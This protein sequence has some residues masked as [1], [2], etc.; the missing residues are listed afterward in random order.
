M[1]GVPS[2]LL[3]FIAAI[4]ATALAIFSESNS[5]RFSAKQLPPS[6]AFGRRWD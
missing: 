5:G 6:L 3:L 2:H 4:I 1:L